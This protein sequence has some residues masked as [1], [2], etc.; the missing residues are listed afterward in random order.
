MFHVKRADRRWLMAPLAAAIVLITACGVSNDPDGWASPL[1]LDDADGADVIIIRTDREHIA[2]LDISVRPLDEAAVRWEFPRENDGFP[3][4]TEPVDAHGFYGTPALLGPDGEE[5]ILADYDEGTVYAVR[6]DGTSARIIFDVDG[7]VVASVIVDPDRTTAYITATDGC[8]YAVDT[9]SPGT[10]TWS[11]CDPESEVWGTP[12]LAQSRTYGGL[13]LVPG[14][15]GRVSALQIERE[16]RLAWTFQT[17]AAIAGNVVVSE[18]R[19]YLG[20]FNSIFFALDVET[21]D[22]VWSALGADW[23]WTTALVADGT[24][25]AADLSGMVWAW[26]VDSGRL[27]WDAPYD[28]GDPVRAQPAL[29]DDGAVLVIVTR[30]AEFHAI[31]PATGLGIWT[32]KGTED[33]RPDDV[34]ADPLIRGDAILINDEDGR[35][36]E[37]RVNVDVVCPVFRAKEAASACS[38]PLAAAP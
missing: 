31:V 14:L 15:N 27:V 1:T 20:D 19:A 8:V 24:V 36:F 33:D 34:L 21:G 4:L 9:E 16:G 29:T 6:T 3:G 30:K 35:L 7:R 25:Y 37:A 2:A 10:A 32:T 5:L 38:P 11:F 18:G 23:F 22:V 28:A 13:L 17:D 12:D 26:D